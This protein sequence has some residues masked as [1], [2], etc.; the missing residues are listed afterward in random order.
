VQIAAA[1]R[2]LVFPAED[3]LFTSGTLGRYSPKLVELA[4]KYAAE[5]AGVPAD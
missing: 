5:P 1:S 2:D 3:T 4:D